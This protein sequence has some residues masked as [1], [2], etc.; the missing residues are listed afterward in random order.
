VNLKPSIT[1]WTGKIFLAFSAILFLF[2]SFCYY[3]RPDTFAAIT[4]F[5]PWCWAVLGLILALPLLFLRKYIF[6]IAITAWLFFMFMFAEE[7]KCLIRQLYSP[8]A[9]S[10]QPSVLRVVSLNCAGR[11]PKAAEEVI[12]YQPDIVLLQEAPLKKDVELLAQKL[13]GKEAAIAWNLDPVIIARGHLEQ[14]ILSRTKSLIMTQ[15]HV[16]MPNGFAMELVSLRLTPPTI[17]LNIFSPYNWKEHTDGRL[18]R[19]TQ[20][21]KIVEQITRIPDTTPIIVGGDFNASAGDGAIMLLSPYL[22]DTGKY[23][24]V[25]WPN[26][27]MNT[28]PLLRIDQIWASRHFKVVSV[29]ARKT[30][31]SDHRIVICDLIKNEPTNHH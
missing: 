18:L 23:A 16:T 8:C 12:Q 22:L 13:F 11:N 24:G 27:A 15:A 31:Y 5:P 21:A 2:V 26:T 10:K 17:G 6:I 29:V 7:S 25:G 30:Q 1:K 4:F 19:R 3:R 28:V 14:R 20:M 9:T